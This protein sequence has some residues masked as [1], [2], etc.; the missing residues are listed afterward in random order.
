MSVG[1]FAGRS[2]IGPG[3][4]TN[5]L[6]GSREPSLKELLRLSRMGVDVGFV[7]TGVPSLA[8]ISWEKTCLL[9]DF[10]YLD[11]ADRE[12]AYWSVRK[13]A[14]EAFKRECD[15]TGE[16]HL[17][18]LAQLM[19]DMRASSAKEEMSSIAVGGDVGQIVQAE[20]VDQT[21]AK[22]TIK[23]SAAI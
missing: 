17:R 4:M 19:I 5:L 8:S 18:E 1:E 12:K 23:K 9:S 2:F 21:G 10:D 6:S 15:R 14:L 13:L 20:K 16:S 7:L 11:E 22:I 3:A